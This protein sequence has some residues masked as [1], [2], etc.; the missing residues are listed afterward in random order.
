MKENFLV[1]TDENYSLD[2]SAPMPT[3]SK[4]TVL[5]TLTQEVHVFKNR[6][7]VSQ[8]LNVSRA[9]IS[10]AIKS[11]TRVKDL[12]LITD[13]NSFSPEVLAKAKILQVYNTQ[14]AE[15]ANFINQTTVAGFL[16]ISTSAVTQAIQGEYPV[17]GIYLITKKSL[18]FEKIK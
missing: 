10:M 11:E 9:A 6:S 5:N 14:T 7:A 17:K 15:T 16:G 2:L 8:F 13:K 4:L 3:K 1:T 12:Y 18:S